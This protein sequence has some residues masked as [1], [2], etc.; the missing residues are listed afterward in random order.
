MSK[1]HRLW[2]EIKALEREGLVKIVDGTMTIVRDDDAVK[3]RIL[4]TGPWGGLLLMGALDSAIEDILADDPKNR[5]LKD[6]YYEGPLDLFG[7]IT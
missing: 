4:E 1:L 7:E 2:D 5:G 3:L 6:G